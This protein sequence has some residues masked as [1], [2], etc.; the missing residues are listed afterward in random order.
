MN[1]VKPAIGNKILRLE[2]DEKDFIPIFKKDYEV[3]LNDAKEK[4]RSKY[5]DRDLNDIMIGTISNAIYHYC[6]NLDKNERK[7]Y[8][9]TIF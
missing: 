7:L 3:L 2:L 8:N 4:Q 1:A 9:G 5:P 6:R